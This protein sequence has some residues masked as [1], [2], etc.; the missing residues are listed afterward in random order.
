MNQPRSQTT[1][2]IEERSGN[3]PQPDSHR[4]H[5]LANKS[6]RLQGLL[7][8][9]GTVGIEPTW[10]LLTFQPRIRR[11]V[12]VPYYRINHNVSLCG[13]LNKLK[14]IYLILFLLYPKI[15]SYYLIYENLF[16]SGLCGEIL[17]RLYTY[18]THIYYIYHL[19]TLPPFLYFIA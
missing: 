10:D 5:C 17:K 6:R 13:S 3:D 16:L 7:S 15:Y 19:C 9:V 11:R 4:S 14:Y 8:M 12:Y 2:H 1:R 18:H